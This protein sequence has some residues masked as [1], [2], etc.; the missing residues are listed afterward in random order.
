LRGLL[1][2]EFLCA[3]LAPGAHAFAAGAAGA[4]RLVRRDE[5]M[6]ARA[7]Q[8]GTAQALKN[9]SEFVSFGV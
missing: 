3:V 4:E 8:V 5:L 1:G 9:T 7:D 2:E 6:P